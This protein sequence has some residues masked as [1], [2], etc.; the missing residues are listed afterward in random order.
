MRGFEDLVPRLREFAAAREWEPFHTPR[1]LA[2]A[3]SGEVGELVA[4]LQW[5]SDAEIGA[6]LPEGALRAR[7]ADE[8]ADVLLYLVRFADVCGLDLA[9][10]AHAKIDRNEHRFPPL[11][12]VPSTERANPSA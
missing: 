2:M 12:E 5:L 4:E 3:L 11:P 1:N 9:E 7:V 8:V 10:V 6:Q